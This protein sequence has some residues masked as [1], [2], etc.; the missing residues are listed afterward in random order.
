M[1]H[2]N[3]YFILNKLKNCVYILQNGIR[4]VTIITGIRTTAIQL[5]KWIIIE[6]INIQ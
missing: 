1:C 5:F 2:I 3:N 6:K 4:N